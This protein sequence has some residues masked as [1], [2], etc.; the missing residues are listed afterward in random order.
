MAFYSIIRYVEIII[1]IIILLLMRRFIFKGVIKIGSL[2]KKYFLFC[3]K[4]WNWTIFVIL[5]IIFAIISYEKVNANMILVLGGIIL[6]IYALNLIFSKSKFKLDLSIYF[7]MISMGGLSIFAAI[8]LPKSLDNFALAFI[9]IIIVNLLIFYFSTNKRNILNNLVS[10]F[11]YSLILQ[12][13]IG[14]IKGTFSYL[15]G[16]QNI[17]LISYILLL[18]S[19]IFIFFASFAF[20]EKFFF[21]IEGLANLRFNPKIS[22]QHN[23][24]LY[25]AITA[26]LVIFIGGY[27]YLENIP[28]DI[29]RD[30]IIIIGVA[31]ISSFS[32]V[33]SLKNILKN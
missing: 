6:I 21:C 3:L 14:L 5:S 10:L 24:F 26:N 18:L 19:F 4:N 1:L 11:I 13:N 28:K 15:A 20:I 29:A 17:N 30:F 12:I 32:S 33:S 9:L 27:F 16:T 7:L 31:L 23:K 25:L 8:F 2:T 22:F